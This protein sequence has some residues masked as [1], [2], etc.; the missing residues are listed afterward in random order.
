MA[1]TPRIWHWR[2]DSQQ[3]AKNYGFG[4]VTVGNRIG[5]VMWG[6]KLYKVSMGASMY[7]IVQTIVMNPDM[8]LY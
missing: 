4:I 3:E 8:F 2:K 7:E 5:V 1:V 6:I